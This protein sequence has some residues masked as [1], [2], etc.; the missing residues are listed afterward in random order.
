M[1]INDGQVRLDA[2][3]F[4][5]VIAPKLALQNG[6]SRSEKDSQS[7]RYVSLPARDWWRSPSLL[8]Q[9]DR[10]SDGWMSL[11]PRS[12]N[13]LSNVTLV[14]WAGVTVG[15]TNSEAR[16]RSVHYCDWRQVSSSGDRYEI[17]EDGRR[18]VD[19][20][21]EI[22]SIIEQILLEIPL[23]KLSNLF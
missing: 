8:R 14:C 9:T 22:E 21:A 17:R 7:D 18:Q 10:Q 11:S 12:L 23:L 5:I 1:A 15:P 6:C 13:C 3:G 16:P 4:G 20:L 19:T 2:N